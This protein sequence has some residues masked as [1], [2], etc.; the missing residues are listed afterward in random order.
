MAE[1]TNGNQMNKKQKL[2]KVKYGMF[3]SFTF[4]RYTC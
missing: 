2:E 4:V 1:Q 3:K